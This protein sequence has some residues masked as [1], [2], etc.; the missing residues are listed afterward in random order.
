MKSYQPCLYALQT[1]RQAAI[2]LRKSPPPRNRIAT[3]QQ[4]IASGKR[5]NRPSDNPQGAA[6]VISLRTT[7]AE[8]DQMKRNAGTAGDTLLATDVDVDA[9]RAHD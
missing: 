2:R 7:Q 6:A 4:Q 3:A 1:L 9:W 5:I 8:I